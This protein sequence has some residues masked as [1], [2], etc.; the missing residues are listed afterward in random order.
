MPLRQLADHIIRISE[1]HTATPALVT[2]AYL[3]LRAEFY[4]ELVDTMSALTAATIQVDWCRQ[5]TGLTG[6][7]S[8]GWA[9]W[10]VRSINRAFSRRHSFAREAVLA[11][12][13]SLQLTSSITRPGGPQVIV[14]ICDE[15]LERSPLADANSL[16][17][18]TNVDA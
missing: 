6:L 12:F 8:D 16:G 18:V 13:A 9:R 11:S 15:R 3:S 5:S 1:S 4:L 17:W 7:A 10:Q 2:P 14:G